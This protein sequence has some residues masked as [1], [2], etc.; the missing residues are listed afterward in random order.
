MRLDSTP[1]R[2]RKERSGGLGRRGEEAGDDLLESSQ[3][4]LQGLRLV[5]QEA[6][7]ETITML[8]MRIISLSKS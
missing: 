5:W 1:S 3:A 7:I 2:G 4:S 6:D 8:I